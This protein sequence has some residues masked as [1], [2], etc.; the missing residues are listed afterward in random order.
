MIYRTAYLPDNI[1]LAGSLSSTNCQYVIAI[2]NEGTNKDDQVFE[3]Y[4]P[5]NFEDS[6]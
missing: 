5:F 3:Y 2:A 6:Q 4:V 1:L